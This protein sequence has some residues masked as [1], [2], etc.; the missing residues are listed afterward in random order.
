LHDNQLKEDEMDRT[1]SALAILEMR[2]ACGK[3]ERKTSF[4]DLDE[5]E[6][7]Y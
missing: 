6:G 5:V 3:Y 7:L 2:N 1:H 4:E